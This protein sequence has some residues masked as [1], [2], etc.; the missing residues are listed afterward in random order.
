MQH[1]VAASTIEAALYRAMDLP[2]ASA[3][4]PRPP[5]E[6]TGELAAL[7]AKTPEDGQLYSLRAMEEEQALNFSAAEVDWKTFASK[8]KDPAAGALALADFYHRRLRPADEAAQLLLVAKAPSASSA[9]DLASPA[10]DRSWQA[11]VRILTLAADQALPDATVQA[12]YIAWIARYPGQPTVPAKYLHWL[13]EKKRY[14]D[15][16]GLIAQYRKAFPAD[17]VFPVKAAALVELSRGDADA[18]SVEK[19]L[20]VYDAAF[21]P[22]W[23]S[24]LVQSFYSLL[25]GT[26]RQRRFVADARARLAANPDD[27]NALARIFFYYQQQGRIDTA[28]QEVEAFRAA[29]DARKSPWSAAGLYTLATLMNAAGA[30]AEAARYDFALYGAGGTLPDG[31]TA[32]EAGLAAMVQLLLEQPGQGIDLGAGNLSMYRDIA[33]LDRGPGYWNGILSLWFN[34]ADPAREFSDEEVKA[35]PYFARKKAAELLTL[36]DRTVPN[37]RERPELH[38]ELIG[39]YAEYGQTAEVIAAGQEFLRDFP[40]APERLEVA[41][42]MADAY[43]QTGDTR[44][45]FALYDRMLVELAAKAGP[46]PL[47]SAGGG[48]FGQSGPAITRFP[49][50]PFGPGIPSRNFAPPPNM[51][52]SPEAGPQATP[53]ASA[54]AKNSQA[55]EIATDTEP[56]AK[57]NPGA[58]DYVQL[59]DRYLGRL[60]ATKQLPQALAVL[61]RELDRNPGDPMLYERLANFLGQNNLSAQQEDVYRL[62]M[63][64]FDDTTWY[65]R[66]ARL[67]LRER[68]REAF[69][70]LTK[71]VTD[72][73]AGTDLDRYFAIVPPGGAAPGPAMYL[74]LNL[75]AAKRFP[76]DPVFV[77]NL[78]RAYQARGTANPVA[79][80]ALLR[81]HWWESESLR[82]GFFDYLSR[83]GKLDAELAQL[84]KIV[85]DPKSGPDG[86]NNPAAAREL[87]VVYL[88]GSHFEQSA[89]LLGTLAQAY[90][91]DAE[92]GAQTVSVFRSLAYFDASDTAKAVAAEKNLLAAN[93][94][95]TEALATLGD[96]YAEQKAGGR[97]DLA[98]AAPYWRRIPSIHP[99]SPDGY[100]ESATIFWDYFEFGDALQQIRAA[101]AKFA[102]P[103]LYGYEA[104]AIAEGQRDSAAAIAEYTAAAIGGEQ[105]ARG[106]LLQL[107]RRTA[108]KSL[109]DSASAREVD[110]APGSASALGLRADV[111]TAQ[112]RI[113]ELAPLLSAAVA[114]ATTVDDAAGI[115]QLAQSRQLAPVY[116]AALAREAELTTDPVQRLELQ[117]AQAR[118]M[119]GRGDT[120]AASRVID[121]VYAA[122]PSILGVV[123]ATVDFDTR[124]KQ[125]EK[126]IAVLVEAARAAQPAQPAL[127]LDLR[128]EAANKANEAGNTAEARTL[129]M[130]LLAESPFDPR[131][132]AAAAESYA[133]A[134]DD[135]GLKQFYLDRLA[136]VRTAP[137]LTP[138]ARKAGTALLRRG[139]IPALTRLKDPS[140]AVDQYIAL[141]SA[142]PQDEAAAQEAALYALRYDRK[143]Q[144]LGFLRQTVQA[145]PQ[146][147]RFAVLLAESETTFDDLPAAIAAYSQAIAIRK[148]R[149]DLYTSRAGLEER[150]QRFDEACADFD[151]LY[152]LTYKDPSW[153]VKE[154]ELRTRQGRRADAVKAL[155]T[156][157]IAGRPAAAK[158]DF[159][160]AAQLEKWDLLTEAADYAERGAKLAGGDLLLPSN[161]GTNSGDAATYARI[162]TRLGQPDKALTTLQ[163]AIKSAGVLPGTL[164][165]TAEELRDAHLSHADWERLKTRERTDAA[166]REFDLGLHEIATVAGT[167]YTPE[168]RL[169]YAKI[170]DAHKAAGDL[171]ANDAILQASL[172]GL[173]DREADWRRAALLAE[174]DDR[175]NNYAAYAQ[176]Q[177]GRMQFTDLATTLEA[178]AQTRRAGL[179]QGIWLAAADVY[180]DLGD[181]AAEMRVLRDILETNS[182]NPQVEERYLA[183]ALKRAPGEVTTFAGSRN[184]QTANL[185]VN[186]A[187]A[188]APEAGV[189]AALEARGRAMQLVWRRAYTAL[190]G[191]YLGDNTARTDTAFRDALDDRAIGDK[192]GNPGGNAIDRTER[193]AGGTWFYYGSRYGVWRTSSGQG[194]AEDYLPAELE[195]EPAA[196]SSYTALART[197]AGAGKTDAAL[198]EFSHA[199]EIAP[200]DASVDDETAVLL[201]SA[202]RKDEALAQWRAALATLYRIQDRAAAPETFWTSFAAVLSNLGQR[203]L[204]GQLRPEIEAV[205]RPYIARNGSYRSDELLQAAYRA[206]ATPAEGLTW[207]L[208]LADAAKDPLEVVS[209]IADAA[210]LPFDQREP[211]YL[212]RIALARQQAA[213]A[214]TPADYTVSQLF[215]YEEQLVLFYVQ[216]HEDA[217]A[218]AALDA[219][220]AEHRTGE[221]LVEARIVLAARAGPLTTLLASYRADPAKAPAANALHGAVRVLLDPQQAIQSNR[222]P[223]YGAN[224]ANENEATPSVTD[225]A[226]TG[227]DWANARTIL[228]YVFETGQKTHS[229]ATTDY[230][231]LADARLH[232]NDL[233]GAITL[234]R[235]LTS[236]GE[237]DVYAGYDAASSLLERSAQP[238]AAV[239]FLTALTKGVPW[240]WSFR[241]RLAEAQ[242]NSGRDADQA[243]AGLIAIAKSAGAPYALRVQASKD[244]STK[245][246]SG[247]ALGSAE[248]DLLAAANHD[249]TAARQPYFAAAR[250]A[251]ADSLSNPPQRAGLLLEALAI[252]PGAPNA[253]RVLIGIFNAEFAS[254]NDALAAAAMDAPGMGNILNQPA[255]AALADR[256]RLA[257]DLATVYQRLGRQT[258]AAQTLGEAAFWSPDAAAKAAYEARRQR[259]EDAL[260]I[261]AENAARRPV[262][263][264]G[265]EQTVAVRQRVAS[266][267]LTARLAPRQVLR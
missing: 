137:G 239:E 144:L 159:L 15:A 248:L 179:R 235:Q 240:D 157:W 203:G 155:E 59:L 89:P 39:V 58:A 103:A 51:A 149:I 177:R 52:Q 82:T 97:V 218:Q 67:Y 11:F 17:A 5:K 209:T 158:N 226:A 160:V 95:D 140:G 249:P 1:I 7:I 184:E 71:K 13:I 90:P 29:K 198:T 230:L 231:A 165:I 227:A 109:V 20:A 219:I 202:G 129:A 197:Y 171:S 68:K 110:K 123:R 169:A 60:T 119:E 80:E 267:Q 57:A 118:S 215:Q 43:A 238:A 49:G 151:R 112:G 101:R 241:L 24:E 53:A 187:L 189:W 70:G 193:L 164:T 142:Y 168:Q 200:D 207:V 264:K 50:Q 44:S 256:A 100:L 265:L 250:I 186:L 175:A 105:Q 54:K 212:R 251:V 120:A 30:Y 261:D 102:K 188:K 64:K 79:W 138:D 206:S 145:S 106:R 253:A 135:S 63:A 14:A 163:A 136:M 147:S 92:L 204:I 8:D 141:I 48:A 46:M 259:I 243:R 88:W 42:R 62:A 143:D 78:L 37:A 19:A 234:L 28:K 192:I 178:Y 65:D 195:R 77:N 35:Q 69:S 266:I 12:A 183:L 242:S 10:A 196:E 236:S 75:Y 222:Y 199:L 86:A 55:F 3:L 84:Q 170:L 4:Y 153:M 213:K 190:V 61:R 167:F 87:A 6:A 216:R 166:A 107:A 27:L 128:L 56:Q 21:Q 74:E 131:Y 214:T 104:G 96:L 225:G 72:T 229:T 148:D 154:A 22:L 237:G 18:A 228:E 263:S 182:A 210:W 134:N 181:A 258:E 194:D 34:S 26:H 73:F 16:T 224:Y 150:L 36:L 233:T 47:S 208:S 115:A 32:Q 221:P 33:T 41:N 85:A 146:D 172:A 94:Y 127:A 81:Q 176:L 125:P 93:P 185:A 126:G 257:G 133:R 252:A 245:P 232:T 124:T 262:I 152:V 108:Y 139:L 117:Y 173:K 174:P 161:T 25:A 246:A 255:T 91:A 38:A 217:K 40:A 76:H 211:V 45:E 130:A 122:N 220:P 113:A 191:L 121:A 254:G 156:A 23:P 9:S 2:G 260:A 83:T 31:R 99:A 223:E 201:W 98:A 111:L 180:R 132:V 244:L 66:L 247:L 162:E 205:L 114:R 116:E